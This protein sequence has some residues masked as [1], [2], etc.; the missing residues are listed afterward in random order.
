MEPGLSL[1]L[2]QGV[3]Q[4]NPFFSSYISAAS[5]QGGITPYTSHNKPFIF[6]V[7][8][9]APRAPLSI[10]P[11]RVDQGASRCVKV[12]QGKS[13]QIKA[14]RWVKSVRA[15]AICLPWPVLLPGRLTDWS[16]SELF[17]ERDQ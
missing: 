4:H 7:G 6:L 5:N 3:F 9:V 10:N 13:S 11:V 8:R 14:Y 16:Y 12:N 1:Q 17:G 15:S 2:G